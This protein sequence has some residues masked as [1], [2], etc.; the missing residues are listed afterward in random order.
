MN[1]WKCQILFFFALNPNFIMINCI[2][3]QS[4]SNMAATWRIS[5][6]QPFFCTGCRPHDVSVQ[7]DRI[8]VISY[9]NRKKKQN[10]NKKRKKKKKYKLYWHLQVSFFNSSSVNIRTGV[11]P[12]SN[13]MIFLITKMSKKVSNLHLIWSCWS[14]SSSCGFDS[15]STRVRP[16]INVSA[17]RRREVLLQPVFF[18]LPWRSTWNQHVSR[19]KLK[20]SSSSQLD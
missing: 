13:K 1:R 20:Y 3:P 5:K 14:R 18:V 2:Q 19:S 10:R 12:L 7:P 11:D 6:V 4:E 8:W 16:C 17:V 9:V 15:G